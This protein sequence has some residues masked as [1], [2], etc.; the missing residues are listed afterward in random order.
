MIKQDNVQK[1]LLLFLIGCIG[2]RSLVT[3]VAKN[4]RD[5]LPK[6]S[7]LAA[8]VAAG[9]LVIYVFKLRETGREVF[10]E[11]IWW[12]DYRPLHALLYGLFSYTAISANYSSESWKFLAADTLLGLL[13]F[14]KHQVGSKATM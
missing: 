6:L 10:G 12:N 8:I 7:I 2:T 5:L 14:I 11:K 3:L 9:F 13:L 1:R 4:R